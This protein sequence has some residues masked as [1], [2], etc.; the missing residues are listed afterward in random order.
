MPTKKATKKAPS[1]KLVGIASAVEGLVLWCADAEDDS[2]DD[3]NDSPTPQANTGGVSPRTYLLDLS[4][5]HTAFNYLERRSSDW[6]LASVMLSLH[7][8]SLCCLCFHP[9]CC[10]QARVATEERA[11]C[12][13]G[14]SS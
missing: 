10:P 12:I 3:Y 13:D 8:V 9:G 6:V 2:L 1:G 14:P 5:Q 7:L 4:L 11:A